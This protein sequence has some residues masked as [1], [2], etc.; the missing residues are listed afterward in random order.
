MNLYGENSS[1]NILITATDVEILP[2]NVQKL[3]RR[4]GS[5]GGQSI[6]NRI[7]CINK[8]HQLF[9]DGAFEVDNYLRAR[10]VF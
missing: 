9:I 10:A 2:L 3:N 7:G 1:L 4:F 6:H 8:K 5:E